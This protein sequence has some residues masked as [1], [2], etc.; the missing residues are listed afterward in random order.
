[1]ATR[2][3]RR[4]PSPPA[5]ASSPY[6]P[7]EL[8]PKVA[9]RLTNLQDFFALR[10]GC[11]TYRALLPLTSTNL[12]SQ[13]PLL[14][15][16]LED[17]ESHG[18]FHPTLRRIHHF[19]FHYT[20]VAGGEDFAVTFFHS[21]GCHL[22]IYEMRGLRDQPTRYN[23]SIV[24]PFTRE[25]TCLPS[26]PGHIGRVLLYGD[27]VLTWEF[28]GRA[29][30]YCRLND[31]DWRVASIFQPYQLYSLICVNGV[32]Y[33]LTSSLLLSY[34]KTKIRPNWYFWEAV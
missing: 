24:N 14:F 15:V 34:Q 2:R 12:A 8:I 6:F 9:K 27:L 21:L 22:A 19:R 1:M 16:P 18:L 33:A 30:Q 13:A 5:T 20:P 31:A 28:Y 32:L 23:L 4:S 3:R 11:R 26:H 29:I 10:A 7:P 17:G 25:R